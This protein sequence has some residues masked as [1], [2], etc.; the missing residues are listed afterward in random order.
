L[1][2]LTSVD[3][4]AFAALCIEMAQYLDMRDSMVGMVQQFETGT[5]QVSPELTIAHKS[6][7]KVRQL[8]TEFGMTPS[9]RA[10]LAIDRVENDDFEEFLN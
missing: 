6:L 7:D 4:L 1:G 8:L 10:R 5:R 3:G 2:V 9:S